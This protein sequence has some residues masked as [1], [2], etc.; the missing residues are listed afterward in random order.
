[1]SLGAVLDLPL[2]DRLVERLQVKE[3]SYTCK[4]I[5]IYIYIYTHVYVYV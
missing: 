1:M 2:E 4:Y 3:G 5:Y